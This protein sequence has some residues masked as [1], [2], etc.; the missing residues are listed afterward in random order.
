M[1]LTK[2]NVNGLKIPD[3]KKETIVFDELLPGSGVRLRAG[4][5][6][7]WIAQYRLG[8]KQRRVTLGSLEAIDADEAR[9]RARSVFAK[10][11]LGG[12]PQVEKHSARV[13]AQDTLL[14]IISKYLASYADRALRPKTLIEVKRNLTV[15]WKPL[16]EAPA[17]GLERSAVAGRLADIATE[18]GPF[19]ANRAR[20]YLAAMFNWAIE[21]G[22]VDQN[23][24][25]G[26]GKLTK[27]V[28][29]DRILN[30]AELAL[31]W[32][33]CGPGDY[34]IIIKML[35][36]TGQRREEVA[37]MC[38]N[39]LDLDAN[40]W[41]IA[42]HRTKNGRAHDVPLSPLASAIL[43][44]IEKRSDREYVFG[45]REGP[46]SGWSKAKSHLD[47][48]IAKSIKEG[49]ARAKA[50]PQWRI[51]D[52]RRTTATRMAYLGVQPHVIEAVLNHVSGHKAG[53][54]GIYN[55][56]AYVAEKRTALSIWDEHV[57]KIVGDVRG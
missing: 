22:I 13:R 15:Q 19:A 12:D 1:R 16:H 57:G 8:T 45:S 31:V 27:E 40:L 30:D 43:R 3:D 9:K 29:R 55:R 36:L 35:I 24:V 51:H 21:Q 49:T 46:F 17:N 10:V 25:V 50:M 37:A 4:G 56:A 39:E 48:R 11:H 32:Q 28:S 7:T 54:A 26:T 42:A 6:R 41:S 5:K 38:W 52:L 2:P 23:P 14:S 33:N 47:A 53:V 20:A 44:D 34:G 18:S